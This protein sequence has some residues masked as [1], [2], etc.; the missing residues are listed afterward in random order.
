MNTL[1]LADTIRPIKI[2]RL[3]HVV[4]KCEEHMPG[5]YITNSNIFFLCFF[6][7]LSLRFVYKHYQ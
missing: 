1:R 4:N 3:I 2:H 5:Q 6:L 7:S